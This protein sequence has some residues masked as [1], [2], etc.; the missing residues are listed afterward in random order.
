MYQVD[1]SFS[2]EASPLL[3]TEEPGFWQITDPWHPW[4]RDLSLG[5]RVGV[6]GFWGLGLKV[7]IVSECRFRIWDEEFWVESL[8]FNFSPL[9]HHWLQAASG[10]PFF[11]VVLFE[12]FLPVF[13]STEDDLDK[14]QIA[15]LLGGT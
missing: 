13:W 12:T 2:M 4:F 1:P 14:V 7:P 10:E 9:T 5:F 6:L 11:R 3:S 15:L 8:D